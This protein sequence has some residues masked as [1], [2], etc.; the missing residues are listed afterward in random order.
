MKYELKGVL[1]TLDGTTGF[2]IW[3]YPPEDELRLLFV[4]RQCLL[5][6]F[7]VSFGQRQEDDS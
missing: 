7:G 2:R 4:L 3:T 5:C 1:T 6:L